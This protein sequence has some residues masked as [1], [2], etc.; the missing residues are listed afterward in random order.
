MGYLARSKGWKFWN[1]ETKEF[2]E[3]AHAKWLDESVSEDKAPGQDEGPV[4]D[5]PSNINRLLNPVNEAFVNLV[6]V[7]ETLGLNDSQITETI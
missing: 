7:L 4:P 3:S 1:P 2:I 5:A 6:T